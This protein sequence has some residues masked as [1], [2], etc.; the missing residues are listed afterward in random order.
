VEKKINNININLRLFLKCNIYITQPPYYKMYSSVCVSELKTLVLFICL[1][2]YSWVCPQGSIHFYNRRT[3]SL[4]TTMHSGAVGQL[5]L[6]ESDFD[7]VRY[8]FLVID[9]MEKNQL[10]F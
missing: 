5:D 7:Q 6:V 2:V 3:H 8:Y 10:I 1:E 4:M 9:K